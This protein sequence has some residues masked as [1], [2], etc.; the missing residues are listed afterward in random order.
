M[1]K[2]ILKNYPHP[3]IACQLNNLGSI[4]QALGKFKEALNYH[5]EALGMGKLIY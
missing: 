4:H 3:I 5:E 1:S 2:L